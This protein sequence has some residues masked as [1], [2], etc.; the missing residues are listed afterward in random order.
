MTNLEAKKVVSKINISEIANKAINEINK[1]VERANKEIERANKE[2]DAWADK[3]QTD[4]ERSISDIDKNSTLISY[5]TWMKELCERHGYDWRVA[6]FIQHAWNVF[7][8]YGRD[9]QELMMDNDTINYLV[10][11]DLSERTSAKIRKSV[12]EG[13]FF[14]WRHQYGARSPVMIT[15]NAHDLVDYFNQK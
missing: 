13:E 8:T 10:W 3:G 4:L 12:R 14:K 9:K 2:I 11:E 6:Y 1:E 5:S 15:I 7:K